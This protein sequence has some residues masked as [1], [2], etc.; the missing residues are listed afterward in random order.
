MQKTCGL[1][2]LTEYNHSDFTGAAADVIGHLE[3]VLPLILP[4][5]RLNPQA[6]DEVL[7]AEFVPPDGLKLFS[8]FEPFD[9]ELRRAADLTVQ[10]EW[11]SH[12]YLHHLRLLYDL[13]R[14]YSTKQSQ[15]QEGVTMKTEG[16]HVM[17]QK[18]EFLSPSHFTWFIKP[19]YQI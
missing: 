14:L 2:E 4:L 16:I 12:R 19:T 10:A 11:I 18:A 1:L 3:L 5:S 6:A 17:S 8:I 7:K 13:R 15:S 9:P